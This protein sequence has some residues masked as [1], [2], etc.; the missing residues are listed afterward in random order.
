[1]TAKEILLKHLPK[2][3]WWEEMEN[4]S[5]APVRYVIEA[6]EEY[7]IQEVQKQVLSIAA[8]N[9]N[10]FSVMIHEEGAKKLEKL[11]FTAKD[12]EDA[13][14]VVESYMKGKKF[15]IINIEEL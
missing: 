2:D 6:M 4:L 1:M 3:C 5:N 11:T 14:E 12:K 8:P 10:Q 7:A 9:K 15:E 13:K